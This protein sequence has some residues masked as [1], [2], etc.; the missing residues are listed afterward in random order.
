M[1]RFEERQIIWPLSQKASLIIVILQVSILST[2]HL[3]SSIN[4]VVDLDDAYSFLVDKH[5][6]RVIEPRDYFDFDTIYAPNETLK[7]IITP[8]TN[9]Y[10]LLKASH[11][12]NYFR[13]DHWN[14]SDIDDLSLSAY[15][16][17][18][19][20]KCSQQL[21]WIE[22]NLNRSDTEDILFKPGLEH[23]NL[24]TLIDSF[25]R[26]E[27]NTF[28]G[29]GIWLGSYYECLR[30]KIDT[31]E[32]E[33]EDCHNGLKSDKSTCSSTQYQA[34]SESNNNIKT[35]YCIGKAR[36]IDWPT[37]DQD[38]FKPS[39][40]Y[41]IGMCLPE[42]CETLS[43]QKHKDQL[44]RIVLYNMPRYWKSR[45]QL[46]DMYCLPDPRSPI[47]SLSISAKIF[48]TIC[49]SWVVI[50][51]ASTFLY[52]CHKRHKQELNM[53]LSQHFESRKQLNPLDTVT[54]MSIGQAQCDSGPN[55]T[56][57]VC[58]INHESFRQKSFTS[59]SNSSLSLWLNESPR[60][61][62]ILKA[63]SIT[64]NMLELCKPP[65][66][67]VKSNNNKHIRV[68]LNPLDFIKCL[69]CIFVIFGHIVFIHMQHLSNVVHAIDLSFDVYP[70]ILISL[71][72]FVDT[73]FIISGLLTGYF[74]FKRFNKKS[75][76]SPIKWLHVSLLRLLRL[77]PIYILVYWFV[78]TISVHLADGP[79][80]DY[81]T[82]KNSIKGL[83]SSDPWWKS[84]LYL[85]NYGSMQPTCV[86]PAW[87]IV[88][89]SQYS[90]IVPPF[91]YLLMR[92]ERLGYATL[93]IAVL[94]STLNMSWQLA[95][96]T[97]V[98]TGDVARVR[99]HVYPLLS[100]FAAEFYNTSFNRIGPVA[101]GILGGHILNLY[102][103]GTIREW[104]RYLRG[105]SF[106]LVLALHL[107]VFIFPGL[108]KLTESPDSNV[109]SD[110][111]IFVIS[112]ATIKPLWSLINT[113]FILR[114]VTDLRLHS[115]AVR[116]M[117]HNIWHCLGK[118]C[119]A[120]YLI[121][122]EIIFILLKSRHDGFMDIDWNQIFREFSYVFLISTIISYL[123]HVFFEAPI[124][125]LVT[126][127]IS[128]GY[129]SRP[130]KANEQINGSAQTEYSGP[131][132]EL[133]N[134]KD[135]MGESHRLRGNIVM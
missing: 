22:N 28:F 17:A 66:L 14:Y 43:I 76:S 130:S 121:H 133:S 6:G 101:I 134:S 57:P 85:G 96:Q 92:Y 104:P 84:I 18:N 95:T 69:C 99:L 71:F 42:A 59:R 34:N 108:G 10:N 53:I 73:F 122:Y 102:E 105:L 62:K 47:R 36:D 37:P 111:S 32:F 115:T 78:K 41:K 5:T 30:T 117:S 97:A 4:P 25:G 110:Y 58:E 98:K 19:P 11:F 1:F 106:K 33:R 27:P 65:K 12:A 81:G 56:G 55:N 90:L 77:S 54:N 132:N 8:Q 2:N 100:R 112:N 126:L 7:K 40:T 23:I 38:D 88:V 46:V 82:D 93:L 26:P 45:L 131:T 116:I 44:Q 15:P 64:E 129:N 24:M 135:E 107:F 60:I 89:D 113:I 128:G 68:N 125:N 86:L 13:I 103:K 51:S 63:I 127:A 120:S 123:I 35:R 91:I 39:I 75:F 80:W 9:N 118:L 124:N 83:C 87:S 48:L 79:I 114:L 109:D 20:L 67:L 3:V 119:F 49:F 29:R 94:I 52:H 70:R 74:I 21:N 16:I 31:V 72:N 61:I 50:L